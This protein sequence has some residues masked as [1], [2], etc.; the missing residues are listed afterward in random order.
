VIDGH[1]GRQREA[2][3]DLLLARAF[4]QFVEKAADLAHVARRLRQAF[5]AG[6]EFLEH[7]HRNIDVVFFEAENGGRVVHQH[8]RVQHEDAA[9]LLSLTPLDDGGSQRAQIPGH[10]AFT[11]ANTAAAWPFTLTL[12]HAWRSTPLPSI[13]KV[14]RSIPRN[15]LPYMLFS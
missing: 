4:H 8:I 6:I 10:N 3:I 15:F 2:A 12:R 5:F 9:L 7:R 14:L 11:A 1:G 13:R